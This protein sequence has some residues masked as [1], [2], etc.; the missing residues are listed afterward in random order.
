MITPIFEVLYLFVT[1]LAHRRVLMQLP[2]KVGSFEPA[3]VSKK[4]R[5]LTYIDRGLTLELRAS[6]KAIRWN[7]G[8]GLLLETSQFCNPPL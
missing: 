4:T 2:F 7:E 5:A 1:E 6:P 8:L 3:L